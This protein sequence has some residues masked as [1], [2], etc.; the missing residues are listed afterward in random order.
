MPATAHPNSADRDAS[1]DPDGYE[2]Q[3]YENYLSYFLYDL[4]MLRTG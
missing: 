4:L 1:R 2:N 3:R